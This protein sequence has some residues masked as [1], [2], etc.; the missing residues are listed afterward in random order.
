VARVEGRIVSQSFDMRTRARVSGPSAWRLY[1]TALA[2]A[3]VI[4]LV[5]VLALLVLVM[6][7]DSRRVVPLVWIEAAT[8]VVGLVLNHWAS[9]QK[10]RESAA[11]YTT[12]GMGYPNLEQVDPSTGLV[13]RAAGEPL[14]SRQA[15]RDRIREYKASLGRSSA[16]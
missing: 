1:L 14:L 12:S 16:D 3:G 9:K 11:G 15:Q 4:L 8:L 2:V 6:T 5:M 10:E 7:Q 13:V